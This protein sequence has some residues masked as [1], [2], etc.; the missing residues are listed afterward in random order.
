MQPVEASV[1]GVASAAPCGGG[2]IGE[3]VVLLGE[4]SLG[5]APDEANEE[6]A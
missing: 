6:R 3:V 4:R 5:A 1:V 2:M